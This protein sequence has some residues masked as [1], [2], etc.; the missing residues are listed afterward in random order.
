MPI[1]IWKGINSYGDKRKGEIEAPDQAAALAH[2][3]RLRIKDPV[4]KEK[5]KDLLENIALFKPFSPDSFPL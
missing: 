5:P 4:I 1:Y 3:K 2:V